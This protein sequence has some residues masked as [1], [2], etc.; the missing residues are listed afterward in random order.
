MLAGEPSVAC[1][2]TP[3]R[4]AAEWEG[5]AVQRFGVWAQSDTEPLNFYPLVPPFTV[6]IC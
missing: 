5:M 6:N 1:A 3:A 4:Q 2:L